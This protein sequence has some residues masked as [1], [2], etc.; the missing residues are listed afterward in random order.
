VVLSGLS[1]LSGFV[2]SKNRWLCAISEV[3]FADKEMAMD[4]SR[5]MIVTGLELDCFAATYVIISHL[6]YDL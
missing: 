1:G 5:G 2:D 3:R 4:I 6:V